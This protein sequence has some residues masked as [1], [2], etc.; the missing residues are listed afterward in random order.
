MNSQGGDVVELCSVFH[1]WV[2]SNL[3]ED[4][5]SSICMHYA[6]LGY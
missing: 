3:E 4:T 1:L 2:G 5:V 6:V